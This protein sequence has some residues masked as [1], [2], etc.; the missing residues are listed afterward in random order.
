MSNKIYVFGDSVLKG[1]VLDENLG[2]YKVMPAEST[3]ELA[4]LS[5]RDLVNRSIFGATITKARQVIK[6]TLKRKD[7]CETAVLEFGGNDC[8]F[9]WQQVSDNPGADHVPQTDPD[10]FIQVYEEIIRDLQ[11][12]GIKVI[13]MNL[14]PIDSEYY[15]DYLVNSGLDRQSL[16]EFL[17]DTAM[18]S[19]FQELYSNLSE[20][21]ALRTG[22]LL[23]DVRS[24][25][26]KLRNYREYICLDGLHPSAEGH[27]IIYEAFADLVR[28][29][30]AQQYLTL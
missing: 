23:V 28:S 7:D 9:Q 20:R 4:R 26:L 30:E 8:N 15:L 29:P 12:C 19:R 1:V 13:V 11:A 18:I 2:K 3:R 24:R 10:R 16:L 17:G 22:A 27:R 25:F 14:P 6:R 21:V 5:G